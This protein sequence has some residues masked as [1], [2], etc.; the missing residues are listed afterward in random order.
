MNVKPKT[1]VK[2]KYTSTTYH[3]YDVFCRPI[4]QSNKYEKENPIEIYFFIESTN[5]F[6]F[7]FHYQKKKT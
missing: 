2:F 4:I 5:I 1:A 3:I 6:S 7:H